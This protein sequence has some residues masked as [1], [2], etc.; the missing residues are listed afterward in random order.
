MHRIGGRSRPIRGSSHRH[1]IV[2]EHR[3]RLQKRRQDRVPGNDQTGAK[4][5]ERDA[6]IDEDRQRVG[7]NALERGSPFLDAGHDP[8]ESRLSQHDARRSLC[9]VGRGRDGDAQLRLT[10][11]W[12]VVG[13]VAAHAD[14]MALLL[15][16]LDRG[17]TSA[18]ERRR[19]RL[20]SQSARRSPECR[21]AGKPF[22]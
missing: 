21:P 11:C 6:F 17:K 3:K 19:H 2:G 16:R 18:L 13:A 4:H 20:R 10:Q 1:E 7:Q 22:R 5:D 12:G 8:A 14:R 15:E 9:N